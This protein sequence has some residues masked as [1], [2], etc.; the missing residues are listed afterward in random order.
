MACDLIR[1]PESVPGGRIATLGTWV[2]EHCLGLG[3]GTAVVKPMRHVVHVAD[4]EPAEL[5][6][7]GPALGRV[8]RAV[9]FAASDGGDAPSQVYV[10]LW[11]HAD[12]RPGHI[13]FVVQPVSDALMARFDAHGPQLQHRMFQA[14]E[15]MDP[16]EMRAAAG[17]IRMHL[18][19]GVDGVGTVAR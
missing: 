16:T 19:A 5:A 11:S 7:M 13:H 18:A 3:V 9:S 4:L 10:C 17:R 12:Q 2:V 1:R 14:N 6:D 8:A 15:P